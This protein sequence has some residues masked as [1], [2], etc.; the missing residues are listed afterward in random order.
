M[1]DIFEQLKKQA[2][3]DYISDLRGYKRLV[4]DKLLI[5]IENNQFTFEDYQEVMNYIY[6]RNLKFETIEELKIAIEGKMA[7]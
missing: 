2:G 7:E 6:D 5:M 4:L 1:K 3:C